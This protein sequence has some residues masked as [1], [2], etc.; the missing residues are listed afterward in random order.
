MCLPHHDV[1]AALCSSH[2]DHQRDTTYFKLEAVNVKTFLIKKK[3]CSLVVRLWSCCSQDG[4][5][6]KENVKIVYDI[7]GIFI[8]TS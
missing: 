5:W 7:K 8:K 6:M 4:V 2:Y 3:K 1:Q